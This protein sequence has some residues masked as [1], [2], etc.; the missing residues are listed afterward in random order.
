VLSFFLFLEVGAEKLFG[1]LPPSGGSLVMPPYRSFSATPPRNPFF[2]LYSLF[3]LS[4]CLPHHNCWLKGCCIATG[5]GGGFVLGGCLH[6]CW[7]KAGV[8]SLA[9]HCMSSRLLGFSP[10]AL[11]FP[12]SPPDFLVFRMNRVFFLPFRMVK[13]NFLCSRGKE[14]PEPRSSV[15]C[16]K[17]PFTFSS[18]I[19]GRPTY[20]N[21]LVTPLRRPFF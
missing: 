19:H 2:P 13:S 4:F 8:H 18:D 9:S 20:L 14:Y 11:A 17:V 16:T 15:S 3:C 12:F 10:G 7:A 21:K 6:P 5:Y 1:R